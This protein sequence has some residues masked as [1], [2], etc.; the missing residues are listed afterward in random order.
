MEY[1]PEHAP[2]QILVVFKEPTRKDFAQDFG[3][4]L[5]YE[6]SDEEYNHGDA[7]IFQTDVGGEEEAIAKFVPCSEFVDWAGFRDIKIEARWESLEQA[8]AG[9]QS[10]QEEASL[11]DN[12]YNEKLEKMVERLKHLLD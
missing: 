2:G 9:I 1:E 6:L 10:L 7:Y 11:P 8:M 4:T 5:G 12:L 3:K